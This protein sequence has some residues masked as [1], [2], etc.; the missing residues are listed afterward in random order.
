MAGLA[1]AARAT[2]L[3]ADVVVREK[4]TRPGGSMLLSSC[5]VW[6]Y[7]DWERFREECPRGDEALQ[8]VV[9][10]GLDEALAW[11]EALGAP[12]VTRD[13]AN[14]LTTGV[15]FEPGG[16]TETLARRAGEIRLGKPLRELP[17]GVPVVL[18]TGGFQG[19][20]DLVRE[21]ITPEAES[22][23]LRANP[24]SAGDGLALA[25][26]AGASESA[27]LDEFYGRNLAAAPNIRPED[28]VPLA[29]V[30]AK[31]SRVENLGGETYEP[32]TWSEI[33]VAQWTARQPGARARYV[34]PDEALDLL[35]RERTVGEVIDAA[36]AAGAPVERRD[37][38]T[39]V[40]VVAAITTTLGGIAVD[41]RGRAA[42][43]VWAAGADAGGISLGGWSSA[44][45]S[46]LVFGLRAA[47]A[48]SA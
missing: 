14:P 23:V 37:G 41:E 22:L 10:E 16:L 4:G 3:G 26:A 11:L 29:Q 20:A 5:V 8:R 15:R 28:F 35:V 21:H 38:E 9:W 33:D 30:Y 6:R 27:G 34:V 1:A 2:E 17:D 45:A 42:D 43:G 44:L 12:L 7:R 36:R 13:T 31:H 40:E 39:V 18:A 46:A 25:V 24:W 47:E 48:A 32:R 19:N